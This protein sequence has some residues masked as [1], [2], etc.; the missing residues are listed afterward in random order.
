MKA[1][2][3]EVHHK[4]LNKKILDTDMYNI[5]KQNEAEKDPNTV[6]RSNIYNTMENLNK[7]QQY[8]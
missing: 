8:Q 6:T 3:T 4:P 5:N 1:I 2:H 7:D